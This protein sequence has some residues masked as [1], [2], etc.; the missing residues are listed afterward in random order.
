MADPGVMTPVYWK[1]LVRI[2]VAIFLPFCVCVAQASVS[3]YPAPTPDFPA[4]PHYAVSIEQKGEAHPAFVHRSEAQWR[5]NISK[6]ISYTGFAFEGPVQVTVRNL[7]APFQK[8]RVLPSSRNI[9]VTRKDSDA[10]TFTLDKP[11]QFAIEFDESIMHPL[12]VFADAPETD[13]PSPG[14]PKLHH[15]GPGVHNLPAQGLILRPGENVYLAP[16]AFVKGRIYGQDTPGSRVYGRGILSGQHLPGQPVG[17]YSVPHMVHFDKTSPNVLIEGITL[18]ASPHYNIVAIGADSTIRNV[19]M[20]GWWLGTDGISTGPNGLI[21]DCFIKANDD[22]IKVYSPG[23]KVHRCIIW[24]M[25]N[26]AAFNLSWNLNNDSSGFH[27]SDI[28]IIRVEHRT[29]ANNRGIFAS[30]H[31]GSANLSDYL[32]ENIRIENANWRLFLITIHKTYWAKSETVGNISNLV[33]RN[34]TT[35]RSFQKASELRSDEPGSRISN[36]LFENV[37]IAGERVE[38]AGKANLNYDP[39]RV[40]DVRVLSTP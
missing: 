27:V 14:T 37:I 17:E 3:P 19:K 5:T 2:G 35:D 33:F 31:G 39:A 20:M 28:D 7:I 16:G 13:V 23:M 1:H 12:L 18:V 25:E 9:I 32:F 30:I 6:D 36:V 11:G 40:L 26:G 34:I 4:S 38:S 8:A 10:I 29:E 21:V 15:F 22:S 24:Q